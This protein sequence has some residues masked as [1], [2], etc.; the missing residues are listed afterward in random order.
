MDAAV[1]TRRS[2]TEA[3]DVFRIGAP[4]VVV[5]SWSALRGR[6]GVVVD[7]VD[8]ELLV[9]LD[10]EPISLRFGRGSVAVHVIRGDER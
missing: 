8:D 3:A 5:A 6:S 10:G 9:E 4:V 1:P 2:R 7:H